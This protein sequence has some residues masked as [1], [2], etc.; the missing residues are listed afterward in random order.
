MRRIYNADMEAWLH[1]VIRDYEAHEN[2]AVG[3]LMLYGP[4]DVT[5]RLEAADWGAGGDSWSWDLSA[6]IWGHLPTRVSGGRDARNAPVQLTANFGGYLLPIFEGRT[7]WPSTS[8]DYAT[9]L[10]AATP[11]AYL[12][13]VTLGGYVEYRGHSPQW[14]YRD[15]LRRV[16][17]YDFGRL[18]IPA[19]ESPGIWR[20]IDTGDAFVDADTPGSIISF[21]DELT[22]AMGFD[23]PVG[24]GHHVLRDV[25]TGE[26]AEVAWRYDAT[27]ERQVLERFEEPVP[28]APDEQYRRVIVRDRFDD[29]TIRVREIFAVDYSRWE[30]PPLAGQ[31]LIID[32]AGTEDTLGEPV[33]VTAEAAYRRAQKEAALLS[34]FL[35]SGSATV[36][37]N[38]LLEPKDVVTFE[39]KYEDDTGLYRRLWRAVLEGVS[40]SFDNATLQ[41][42]LE[43]TCV[44]MEEARLPD[45]PIVLRGLTPAVVRYD[46]VGVIVRE[47]ARTVSIEDSV[48]WAVSQARTIL[49]TDEAPATENA[50]TVTIN[51]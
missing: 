3:F 26:T 27:D 4:L 41:T 5:D 1:E 50:R 21:V 9:E 22:G 38:P 23:D 49:L 46:Q 25:G 18:R 24:R 11:G 43:F 47:N 16:P 6:T 29:G 48:T 39:S 30:N 19:F 13:K 45:E 35:H 17:L 28:A 10:L 15:A 37:F 20:T 34:N 31:D 40:H 33:D 12:D 36:A 14:V 44:L 51:R 32:F 8:D 7:S 42:E 2:L